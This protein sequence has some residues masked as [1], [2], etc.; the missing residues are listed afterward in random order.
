MC[1]DNDAESYRRNPPKG[2]TDPHSTTLEE[3]ER[4]QV[5]RA[6]EAAARAHVK[7]ARTLQAAADTGGNGFIN[8]ESATA[9]AGEHTRVEKAISTLYSKI[10]AYSLVTLSD[11]QD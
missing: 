6:L 9:L 3:H 2:Y 4:Q 5:L 10:T 1:Y 11:N 7:H 8:R